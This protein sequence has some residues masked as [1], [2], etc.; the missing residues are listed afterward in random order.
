MQI[1]TVVA[2]TYYAKIYVGRRVGYGKTI[3]IDEKIMDFIQEY[4]NKIGLCVTTTKT[5]YIYK[6]GNEPGY[7]VGLIN[8]PRFPKTKEEIKITAL[9]LAEKLLIKMEQNR[10]SV[11]FPDETIML[12]KKDEN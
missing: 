5:N 1:K 7:I 12:E 4:V 3:H 9:D 8:Y 10:V 2:E 11:E 6:D